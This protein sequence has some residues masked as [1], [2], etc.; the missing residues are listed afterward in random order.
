MSASFERFVGE[1]GSM[2]VWEDLAIS[3]FPSHTPM[4]FL[5]G[6]LR[7]RCGS[8]KVYVPGQ[9]VTTFEARSGAMGR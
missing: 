6:C 5:R 3:L 2:E 9:T 1:Y 4:Q 8:E 7:S